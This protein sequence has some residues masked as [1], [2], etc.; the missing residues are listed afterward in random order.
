[1]RNFLL[2]VLC[3]NCSLTFS[4]TTELDERLRTYIQNFSLRPLNHIEDTNPSSR[5]GKL[6]KIKDS[7]LLEYQLS[8]C[9][10]QALVNRTYL[11]SLGTGATSEGRGRRVSAVVFLREILQRLLIKDSWNFSSVLGLKSYLSPTRLYYIH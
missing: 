10:S 9:H 5:F 8:T 11:L 1:M 6:S 2:I 3:L 4:A 7:L